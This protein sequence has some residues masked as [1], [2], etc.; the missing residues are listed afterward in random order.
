MRWY[1]ERPAR[2]AVQVVVDLLAVAWL[3][4]CWL[5]ASAVHE[6]VLRLQAPARLLTSAGESISGAFAGA[7]DGARDIPFVGA[8]VAGAFDPGTTAGEGLAAAGRE[9]VETIA[10]AA[11]G[12]SVAVVLLGVLPVL[13]AWLPL[14]VRYARRAA[15]AITARRRDTDLLALRAIARRPVRRLLSISPDPAGAWRRADPA[16]VAGL[17]ALEL[18]SLG[19]RSPDPSGPHAVQVDTTEDV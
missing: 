2:M 14:R 15:S 10:T 5:A 4:G 16:V 13:L 1:A 3:V 9:Q 7:A 6:F 19:L 18:R 12:A 11:V 8:D 17:A